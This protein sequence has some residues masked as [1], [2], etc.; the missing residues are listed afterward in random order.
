MPKNKQHAGRTLPEYVLNSAGVWVKSKFAGA[1]VGKNTNILDHHWLHDGEK[2]NHKTHTS[3]VVRTKQNDGHTN[4]ARIRH[5]ATK[6][7]HAI[8]RMGNVTEELA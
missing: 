7:A 5:A 8:K 6:A 3:P 4:P 2:N 1:R